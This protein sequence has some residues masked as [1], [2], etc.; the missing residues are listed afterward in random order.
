[1]FYWHR[2]FS[3]FNMIDISWYL[4]FLYVRGICFGHFLDF[5]WSKF[6]ET[7]TNR[8]LLVSVVNCFHGVVAYVLFSAKMIL[9]VGSSFGGGSVVRNTSSYKLP[10]YMS[11]RNIRLVLIVMAIWYHLTESRFVL[12]INLSSV[13]WDMLLIHCRSRPFSEYSTSLSAFSTHISIT[14]KKSQVP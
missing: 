8:D 12:P 11:A 2:C 3:R 9:L 14:G 10:L 4:T 7:L 5:Y 6:I 13:S 1:M